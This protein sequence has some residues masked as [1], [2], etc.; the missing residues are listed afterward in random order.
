MS[1]RLA[2]GCCP[3][4]T[5]VVAAQEPKPDAKPAGGE[6]PAK[7]TPKLDEYDYVKRDVM[8]RCATR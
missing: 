5:F 4:C 7:F 3:A 6:M 8:V 1:S 2:L